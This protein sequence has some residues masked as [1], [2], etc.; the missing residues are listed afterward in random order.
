MITNAVC[1]TILLLLFIL[2]RR[3]YFKDLTHNRLEDPEANQ[4]DLGEESTE[5]EDSAPVFVQ[6]ESDIGQSNIEE[7]EVVHRLKQNQV[8]P[9]PIAKRSSIL[10]Q[11][12]VQSEGS[13]STWFIKTLTLSDNEIKNLAG[14][15]AFQYLRFQRYLIAFIAFT[16]FLSITIVLPLNFQGDLKGNLTE[17]G[18]TT[19]AN[20]PADSSYLW[21]HSTLAFILFPV[22]IFLMRQFSVGLKFHD[23]D[24]EISRTLLV[25]G[26]PKEARKLETVQAHFEEAYPQFQVVDIK[27][28][29]D[30]A[31]LSTLS[32]ELKDVSEAKIV[33]EKHR[34]RK[35]EETEM[36]PYTCSRYCSCFCLPCVNKV[37]NIFVKFFTSA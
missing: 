31:K 36:I 1:G 8:N 11:M 37:G 17:F 9:Q 22:A 33:G 24:L 34:L 28:A 15:D 2:I 13:F 12:A 29:Y 30:V 20:L 16:C 23:N 18:H 7:D 4:D 25:E 35:E 19:L 5:L 27:F 21:V 6:I 14:F 3:L 32:A 26:I 10:S